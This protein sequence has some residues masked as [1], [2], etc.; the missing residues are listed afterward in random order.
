[1]A[2]K[3]TLFT[4]DLYVIDMSSLK[5]LHDRYPKKTFPSI[6]DKINTLISE[7]QLYSHIEVYR[8]IKNT[9]N[10]KDKLLLWSNKYKKIFLGIDDCQRKKITL[11]KVK[12]NPSYWQNKI[13]RP[14]PWADPN[15]I[16]IAI[17]EQAVIVTQEHKN[18]YD[19]IPP[20]AS[21]FGIRS[22][23]LLELFQELKIKL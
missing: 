18:K 10:P 4:S 22:L 6:W 20:I 15:L 2:V 8:E 21:Q 7:G 5:E 1:M 11:I 3:R 16:A 14:G 23:N 9:T 17:C 12:Y 13:N 19:N